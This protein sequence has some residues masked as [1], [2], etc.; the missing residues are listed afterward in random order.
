MEAC[1]VL[2][3][4]KISGAFAVSY[5][6]TIG[7]PL[8]LPNSNNNIPDLGIDIR[9]KSIK[10][11]GLTPV[12]GELRF[13]VRIWYLD[14]IKIAW[15]R[16]LGPLSFFRKTIVCKIGYSPR[17]WHTS[18]ATRCSSEDN[19]LCAEKHKKQ[20]RSSPLCEI[21]NLS[22][23]QFPQKT[24]PQT[25]QLCFRLDILEKG[26]SQRE[27]FVALSLFFHDDV[28][29]PATTPDEENAAFG[30]VEGRVDVKED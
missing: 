13:S 24:P 22:D 1:C 16:L 12:L 8:C 2:I 17:S 5:C 29:M 20:T 25:L 26:A 4:S 3:V 10:K 19:P 27:Q 9:L 21:F 15:C 11:S 6:S 30:C 28:S 7:T 18:V 23:V 14:T